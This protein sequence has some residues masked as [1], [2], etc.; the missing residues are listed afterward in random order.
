MAQIYAAPKELGDPPSYDDDGT[1]FRGEDGR[2]DFQALM[3]AEDEWV[4][5]VSEAAKARHPRSEIIGQE[6]AYP[7][8][9]GC[10][11]YIVWET[12]PLQL[13]HIP[14]GD[15]WRLPAAHERGLNLAEVKA[16]CTAPALFGER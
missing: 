12:K 16:F 14:V 1:A 3:E 7:M 15:A 2:Y 4:R 10:A 5:S 9:D 8:G 6:Y 11:R 13:I